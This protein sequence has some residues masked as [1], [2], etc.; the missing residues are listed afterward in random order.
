MIFQSYNELIARVRSHA[1][2]RRMAIAACADEHTL[3]AAFQA[4]HASI[5]EPVLVGDRD[6]TMEILAAMGESVAPESIYDCPEPVQAAQTAVRLV[7]EGKAE[8]L[9]K[10]LL[11]TKVLLKAVVNKECG[12]GTGRRMISFALFQIPSYHKLIALVDGGMNTYPDLD[13]KQEII[14]SAVETMHALG[15]EQPKVGVLACV[16]KIN[17]KMPETVEADVLRQRNQEGLLTGCVVEGPISLDCAL[18]ADICRIKGFRSPVA[19]DCDILLA[20]NI[21]AANLLGKS[22]TVC[23]GAKMAGFIVGA[24]CP[25]VLVSRGSDAEEKYNSIAAAAALGMRGEEK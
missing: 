1:V 9:M 17:P 2:P 10:G 20:P 25:I 16:E 15:V 3:Q 7:R 4:K 23:A 12:L 19:G 18:R 8:F 6:K 21:H 14:E 13:Q 22:F 24:A 11:D 5:A